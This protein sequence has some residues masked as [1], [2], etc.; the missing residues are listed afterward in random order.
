MQGQEHDFIDIIVV[1]GSK[2]WQVII[3]VPAKNATLKSTLEKIAGSVT[4]K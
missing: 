3:M 1:E 4:F 2:L